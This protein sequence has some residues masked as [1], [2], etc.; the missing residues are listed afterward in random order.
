MKLKQ[1][2][3]TKYITVQT[4]LVNNL[5]QIQIRLLNEYKN[6]INNVKIKLTIN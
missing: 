3:E 6:I 1:E 5:E 2:L 4:M